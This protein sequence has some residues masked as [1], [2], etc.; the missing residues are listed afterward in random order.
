MLRG[1]NDI[2]HKKRICA[3]QFIFMRWVVVRHETE[4]GAAQMCLTVRHKI[5]GS[6]NVPSGAAHIEENGNSYLSRRAAQIE[7]GQ[8][9]CAARARCSVS[10]GTKQSWV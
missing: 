7:K 10:T 9:N 3:S 6:M 2:F 8:S 5:A 4:M 1:L